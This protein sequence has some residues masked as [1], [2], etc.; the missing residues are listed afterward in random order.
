MLVF[1][2]RLDEKHNLLEIVRKLSKICKK[3]LK[4]ISKNALFKHIFRKI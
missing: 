2:A 1:R 4:Q 3:F